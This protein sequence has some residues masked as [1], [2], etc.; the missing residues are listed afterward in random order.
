MKGKT[1]KR[2]ILYFILITIFLTTGHPLLA[3]EGDPAK[4]A[5]KENTTKTY[6]LENIVV[7]GKR[8][9][10]TYDEGPVTLQSYKYDVT[11]AD[12]ARTSDTAALL[13]DVPGVSLQL[14]GGVS[15]LPIIRGMADDRLRIKV[16]GMDLI[17]SCPNHMNSPLSY[18]DPINVDILKVFAGVTPVS[19][20]G[21]SIG[22][23][24]LV[25][26]PQPVF[27]AP[28]EKSLYTAEAGTFYRSNGHATGGNLSLM[29]AGEYLSVRYS[30]SVV[31]AGNYHAAEDFK[32][33]G[34]A[35]ID[36]PDHFLAGDEVG[37]SA[38]KSENHAMDLSLRHANHLTELKLA[39]QHIPYE[40]FPNQR[41]DMTYNESLQ[42]NIRYL[43][44]FNWGDL[45]ARVYHERTR[46]KMD[47]ADD[48]QF[49]YGGPLPLVLSPGM[50][51]ETEGKNTGARIVANVKFSPH[52]LMRAGVELHLYRLDDWWPPSPS[53]LTGMINSNGTP[54][55]VAGM[56][57]LTFLNINDGKRDRIGLFTEWEKKVNPQWET[58]LGVRYERVEMDTGP[59][60]G[61]NAASSGM[62]YIGYLLS[63]TEF[64]A[65]DRKRTDNNW[66][67]TVLARYT[68][69]T[70]AGF[71]FAY[72]HKTRSP[73]L[74]ERYAWSRN[75]M[76]LIMNNFAGDGNGYLGNPD[77][78]QEQADT[79]SATFDVH[80]TDHRAAF[81]ITPYY[82]HVTDYIDAVQWNR[83]TNQPVVPLAT[84]QF[85]ILKYMN[86]TARI[87]GIDLSGHIPIGETE[88]FGEFSLAGLLNYTNGEDADTNDDLYNIMPL[89]VKLTVAQKLGNFK[90]SVEFQWVD[91]KND[92]CIARQEL[93]TSSYD[94]VNLRVG[95][96]WKAVRID[97]G[98]ENLFDKFYTLPLGGAYAGQ[99]AT[100]SL[101]GIAWGI[102]IPGPGRSFYGAL[103][104]SF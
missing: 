32:A 91:S 3:L 41:M 96:L 38:Y 90:S 69:N 46:H 73:N 64:N 60:Q 57:P 13:S 52:D 86:K 103:K 43:G 70:I 44:Q 99:G 63:A 29:A 89:N 14:N 58:L 18:I 66:D 28:G 54:A 83:T 48:K 71:E 84:K 102:P 16:D 104:I 93:K 15:S 26:S 100:M 74:Y 10:S 62:Y 79:M 7:S 20:G 36:K 50:P 75:A 35:S 11:P 56:A 85:V 80:S 30:G 65:L 68:P 55:T 5:S 23:T 40:G 76:A 8:D 27:A 67:A 22:G 49:F 59:V 87:Y 47:F 24:I 31:K 9:I 82:T 72:A 101:A 4:A 19:I 61:Y 12:Q 77:L 81:K 37:S 42:A 33:A 88:N 78:K 51:M 21:D 92:V 94:L 2:K 34:P 39:Y 6:E 53:D 1:M 97:L 95:Y 25:N 45:E 98:I 17:S